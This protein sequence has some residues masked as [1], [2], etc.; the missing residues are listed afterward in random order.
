MRPFSLMSL[1]AA[2]GLVFGAVGC[3]QLKTK[4]SQ[5]ADAIAVLTP[6]RDNTVNG[7]VRFLK[8][9]D[10]I[11]VTAQVENLTPGKHG[12]HIHTFGDCSAPDAASAG[13]HFNP[14]EKEHGSPDADM[15]HMGDF[16]NIEADDTGRATLDVVDTVITLEGPD[17]IIG[18]SVIV[19]AQEDDLTSQ[20]TGAA[21]ARLACGVIGYAAE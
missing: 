19:H 21:G 14:L 16:G 12:F 4:S 10:G 1:F 13:G 18:R 3:D 7:V 6:T 2:L 9:K 15:R 5:K 20:P 17:S 11:R 8:T